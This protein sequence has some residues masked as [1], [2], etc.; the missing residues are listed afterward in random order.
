MN[1]KKKPWGGRFDMPTD[2]LMEEFSQSVQF[3]S[4]LYNED[5][6]GSIAHARML[7]SCGSQSEA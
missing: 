4:R 2:A 3:D 5:I 6:D 1:D 7:S